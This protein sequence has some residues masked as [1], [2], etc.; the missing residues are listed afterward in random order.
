MPDGD[1]RLKAGHDEKKVKVV[2]ADED[3]EKAVRRKTVTDGPTRREPGLVF[4]IVGSADGTYTHVSWN[5]GLLRAG[6]TVADRWRSEVEALL[7]G[8]KRS[9]EGG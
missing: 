2:E 3:F 1:A 6:E 9:V 8:V 5:A 4:D 7:N